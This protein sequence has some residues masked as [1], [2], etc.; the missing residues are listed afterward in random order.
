M[1][2]LLDSQAGSLLGDRQNLLDNHLQNLLGSLAANLL[3]DLL[4]LPVNLVANHLDSHLVNLV[5]F[6]L[7]NLQVYQAVCQAANQV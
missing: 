7:V 2:N 1:L 4:S 3:G 6:P 5:I